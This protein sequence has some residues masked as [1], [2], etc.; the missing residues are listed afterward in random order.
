VLVKSWLASG[1]LNSPWAISPAPVG[2]GVPTTALL[3][4]NFGDGAIRAY[5]QESG[6]LIGELSDNAGH[7]VVIPGLWD[8]KVGPAI[9]GAGT[10]DLTGTLF[11]SAGPVAESHGLFGKIEPLTP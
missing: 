11:F 1:E 2:F 3:V 7:P 8:L 6:D 4:G 9:G 5:D 10:V